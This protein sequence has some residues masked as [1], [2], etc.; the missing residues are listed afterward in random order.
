MA[1][2]WTFSDCHNCRFRKL[3]IETVELIVQISL[4][5]EAVIRT[6]PSKCQDGDV[7]RSVPV[8]EPWNQ[9]QGLQCSQV[10][11]EPVP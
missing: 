9:K 5:F 10:K 6:R 11:S 1:L 8:L 3:H 2:T 4:Q 7:S